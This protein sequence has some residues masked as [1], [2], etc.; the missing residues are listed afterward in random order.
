MLRIS[1]DVEELYII[2]DY[3]LLAKTSE[4]AIN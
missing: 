4:A 3:I 2:P 1:Q